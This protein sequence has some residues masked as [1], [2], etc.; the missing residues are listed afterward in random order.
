MDL[1]VVISE[2]TVLESSYCFL[3][4]GDKAFNSSCV[5]F[6]ILSP[7]E[8]AIFNAASFSLGIGASLFSSSFKNKSHC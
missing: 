7:Y 2:R 6:F 1:I 5:N 4:L 3:A 8:V